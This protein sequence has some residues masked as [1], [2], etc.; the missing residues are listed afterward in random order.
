MVAIAIALLKHL[1]DKRVGST[2]LHDQRLRG[3]FKIWD[4]SPN[5]YKFGLNG[6]IRHQAIQF[7]DLDDDIREGQLLNALYLVYD[8]HDEGKEVPRWLIYKCRFIWLAWMN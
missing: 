3:I 1:K 8:A 2:N 7:L 4:V 5:L 6:P